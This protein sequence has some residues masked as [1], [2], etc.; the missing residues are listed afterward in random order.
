M[1]L[2]GEEPVEIG[3]E[4]IDAGELDSEAPEVELTLRLARGDR[5]S[6]VYFSD[7]TPGYVELNSEYT[8]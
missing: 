2:A 1:A 6:H 3:P 5:F 8:T 7:L 4:A